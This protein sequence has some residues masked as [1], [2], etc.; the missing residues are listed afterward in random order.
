MKISQGSKRRKKEGKT[1][2]KNKSY[3]HWSLLKRANGTGVLC[4]Q[5]TK[6][7]N[8]TFVHLHVE[9]RNG[10]WRRNFGACECVACC[11]CRQ[12]QNVTPASFFRAVISLLIAFWLSFTDV[13]CFHVRNRFVLLPALVMHLRQCFLMRHVDECCYYSIIISLLLLLFDHYSYQTKESNQGKMTYK[14]QKCQ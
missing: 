5:N 10:E 11:R 8:V 6:K 1:W 14:L 13:L 9:K 3:V 2:V 4:C 7:E 12:W